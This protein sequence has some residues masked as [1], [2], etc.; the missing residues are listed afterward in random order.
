MVHL[1]DAPI[2]PDGK[3]LAYF[4]TDE[5][6][7]PDGLGVLVLHAMESGERLWHTPINAEVMGEEHFHW[8]DYFDKRNHTEV[9]FVNKTELVCGVTGGTLLF[10]EITTGSLRRRL[11]LDTEAD[12]LS[13]AL[14]QETSTLWVALSNGELASVPLG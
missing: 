11:H 13:M 12:V 1:P 2:S 9:L 3:W 8:R 14:D 7:P 6:P 10:Y 5:Y 4:G